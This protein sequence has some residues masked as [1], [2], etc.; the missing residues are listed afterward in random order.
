MEIL[1]T[2]NVNFLNLSVSDDKGGVDLY[3]RIDCKI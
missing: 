3:I 1:I 2:V